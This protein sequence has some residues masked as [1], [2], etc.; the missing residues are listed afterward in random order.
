MA[1][2]GCLLML[3]AIPF[4]FLAGGHSDLKV[5][6]DESLKVRSLGGSLNVVDRNA[7]MN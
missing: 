7:T 1:G 6:P 4:D 5:R 2:S 3:P